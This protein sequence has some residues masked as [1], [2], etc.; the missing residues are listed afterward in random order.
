M[1][2]EWAFPN[3]LRIRTLIPTLG[4][5]LT[6]LRTP[7]IKT[8][9]DEDSKPF[10]GNL[11]TH[12]G[13]HKQQVAAAEAQASVGT[14]SPSTKQS[15]KFN[16]GSIKLM[17]EFLKNGELNPAVVKSKKG[18]QKLFAAWLLEEDLPW[19]T[20]E[21]PSLANLFRYLEINYTLPSDTTVRN[22]LATIFAELH[23]SVVKELAVRNS[24]VFC[25]FSSLT[26]SSRRM[27]NQRYLFLRTLGRRSKW[28]SRSVPSWR[29]ISTMIG[30]LSSDWSTSAT[31]M[32]TIIKVGMQRRHSLIPFVSV[33]ASVR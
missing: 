30:N 7:G 32:Q 14:D 33:V 20:G 19:T 17:E 4:R 15:N 9:A 25:W 10:I 26:Q 16:L 13:K 2:R 3:E 6:F 5:I 27:S 8:W 12:L 31:W 22:T 11:A 28:Y 1:T 21:A 24:V 29:R 23:K 18:F